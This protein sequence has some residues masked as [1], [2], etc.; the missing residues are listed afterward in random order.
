M[1]A[2]TPQRR[3]AATPQRRNAAILFVLLCL[4]GCAEAGS[5][6]HR[7]SRDRATV[8]A[9]SVSRF[10]EPQSFDFGVVFPGS[11]LSHT[12]KI[13]N[14]TSET[15]HFREVIR[16][17]RCTDCEL[18][19][20]TIEPNGSINAKLLIAA[21]EGVGDFDTLAEVVFSPGPIRTKLK[22]TAKLRRPLTA[23]PSGIIFGD[24]AIGASPI[25]RE[26]RI[27]NRLPDA[28][29]LEILNQPS[30]CETR[31]MPV[32]DATEKAECQAWLLMVRPQ[33]QRLDRAG[34]FRDHIVLGTPE[35]T[36]QRL[37]ILAEMRIVEPISVR[38]PQ[39]FL[40]RDNDSRR[41]YDAV[42]V[43]SIHGANDDL[44]ADDLVVSHDSQLPIRLRLIS[45]GTRNLFKCGISID[46]SSMPTAGVRANLRVELKGTDLLATV[47]PI[48]C[49][50]LDR[51]P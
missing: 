21:P 5:I 43:V 35:D 3:N 2:A 32:P 25:E 41:T 48:F 33:L 44:V 29:A 7:P 9:V 16:S 12:F 42:V 27:E 19:A 22:V 1:N 4:A 30:W 24:I 40:R 13:E 31:L 34:S 26:L 14:T 8:G 47:V 23:L 45:A 38:P 11:Q 20:R 39:V 6:E 46:Q 36:G 17:C 51:E 49:P 18:S 37:E 28:V 10:L 15:L 50:Q